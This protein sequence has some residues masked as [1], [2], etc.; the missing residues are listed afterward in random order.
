M[1]GEE[2]D[3]IY[4]GLL[5]LFPFGDVLPYGNWLSTLQGYYHLPLNIAWEAGFHSVPFHPKPE[6]VDDLG[7]VRGQHTRNEGHLGP[8]LQSWP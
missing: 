6:W 3:F 8:G 4:P 7:F 1:L 2:E 5:H